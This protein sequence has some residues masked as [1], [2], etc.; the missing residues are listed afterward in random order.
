MESSISSKH[1]IALLNGR[2]NAEQEMEE[3]GSNGPAIGPVGVRYTY[4]VIRLF[5]PEGDGYRLLP[6][7]AGMVKY[8]DMFYGDFAVLEEGDPKLSQAEIHAY[9]TFAEIVDEAE[10][11]EQRTGLRV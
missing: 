4:G 5:E 11:L 6:V 1:Y 7:E 10:R 8:Q 3:E 9:A 2:E